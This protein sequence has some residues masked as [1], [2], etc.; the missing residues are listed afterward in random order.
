M[1]FA[2]TSA[3]LASAVANAGTVLVPYPAG[4]T[5]A[6]FIGANA[7]ANTGVGI[8]NDNDV[9][10]EAGSGVRINLTYNAGDVTVANNTGVTWPAGS[11]LRVQLGRAGMDRPGFA[12]GGGSIVT[13]TQA[14][15]TASDTVADVTGAFSQSVLN[16]NFASLSAKINALLAEVRAIGGIN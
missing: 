1:S 9:Y 13:L 10:P 8:I 16:N 2:V 14:T 4:F 12:R 3:V 6:S 11:A 5:Q 7:A 15:G